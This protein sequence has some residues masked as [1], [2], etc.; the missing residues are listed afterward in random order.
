MFPGCLRAKADGQTAVW[1]LFGTRG[2]QVS[3]AGRRLDLRLQLMSASESE[4][5]S[6][7]DGDGE[8]RF[9][10]PCWRQPRSRPKAN[11]YG[12]S[13]WQP[14]TCVTALLQARNPPAFYWHV[15]VTHTHT[16]ISIYIYI[17]ISIDN[18]RACRCKKQQ[19]EI[20]TP[21]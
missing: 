10:Q 5:E 1:R 7:R 9:S 11:Q 8:R 6:G 17:Y 12:P 14:A 13:P 3:Q 19:K 15:H 21:I 16:H 20:Y 4:I 18:I 2:S